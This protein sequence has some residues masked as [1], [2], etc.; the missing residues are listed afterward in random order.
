MNFN[1]YYFIQS[2]MPT[3]EQ[4]LEEIEARER[5]MRSGVKQTTPLLQYMK[6]KKDEKIKKREDQRESRYDYFIL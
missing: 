6:D 1:M 5:E 2:S 4:V 3:I